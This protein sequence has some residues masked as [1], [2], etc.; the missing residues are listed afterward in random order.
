MAKKRIYCDIS[1][2]E[3]NDD[4]TI[5]VHGIAS[6][7]AVDSDGETIT[8]EAMKAAIPDY[9]KFGAL[10]EM[11]QPSAAGT[12]LSIDVDDT[13]GKTNF[14]ALVVDDAAIK[15]VKT[16][17]YK[18]FSIGGKVTERDPQD[19]KIIKGLNLIEVSLVDRPANP[20]ALL[21]MYKAAMTPEEEV[22]ELAE[23]IDGNDKLPARILELLK[24]HGAADP[25]PTPE[26]V[27]KNATPAA[28]DG[29]VGL[30]PKGGTTPGTGRSAEGD[31]I[32]K[33]MYSVSDFAYT[34]N[35]LAYMVSD[36]AWEAEYEGDNSPVPAKMLDWLKTGT[37]IFREMAEEETQEMLANLRQL[38]GDPEVIEMAA[39]A[40][41]PTTLQKKGAKFSADTKAALADVHKSMKDCCDKMDA[42]GYKQEDEEEIDSATDG[43]DQHGQNN[44]TAGKVAKADTTGID[45]KINAA[46][47]KAMA[48]L[49]DSLEKLGKEKEDLQ[50][51]LQAAQATINAQPLR[52][53]ALLKTLSKAQDAAASTDQT[54]KAEVA[55]PEG[56]VERAEYEMRKAVSSMGLR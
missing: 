7:G 56:T 18:G 27:N 29:S 9:M 26:P 46:V 3:D 37:D 45:E 42:L 31:T 17:V 14:S 13:T 33:G 49:T 2:V 39:K 5:T 21:T 16:S 22:V 19:K 40:G 8:P 23:M 20:D 25:E 53:K 54:A 15:K 50:K 24:R 34:L 28:S 30:P 51:Q 1:K 52:G 12:A 41:L 47:A 48:P 6:S 10:R 32:Q 44:G 4:G 38:V 35:S 11:H 43:Q 36:A 55:P